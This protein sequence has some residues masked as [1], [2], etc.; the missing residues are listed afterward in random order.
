MVVKRD[1]TITNYEVRDIRF[2]TSQHLDGS[3]AMNK[4][5]DY[6]AAYVIFY[7]DDVHVEG[8]GMTFTC[9]RGT[10]VCCSAIEALAGKFINK[11]LS[12]LVADMRATHRICTGDSQLRWIGPEKGAIHLATA[13][14]INA[15]WDLWAKA[16]DKPLWKLV[17]D[18]SPEEFVQS[19]DF[20]YI[21]DAITPEEALELLRK[22]EPTKA[23]RELEMREKGY[24]AYT[25]SAGWLGYSDDKVRR[26]CR[27]A[28]AQGFTHFKQK[29]GGDKESDIRRAKLIREEIGDDGVL[30]MDANQVWDVNEAIEWME[31]LLQFKPHF[32][33]EPTSPDDVLGHAAIRKALYPRTRVATGEHI[34]NRII[35]KQLF[36]AEAIDF[37]QIDSCRVAGVNEILAILLMAKKFNIPVCP[38]AGGVGLCEYVQHLS[39]IDYI[40]VSATTEN[41]VLEYVDHLHEHFLEPVVMKNGRYMAPLAP[42]Y[43]IQ[44]KRDSIEDYT[45]P[46]GKIHKALANN[47]S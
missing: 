6:S 23:Q 24:P 40:C 27:E 11:K 22:N 8:H 34:Q 45:F 36:Q 44:M 47:K 46:G 38:H 30:M 9:G 39:L 17:V 4:D 10:E 12:E 42:G 18:L 15:V 28:K 37:C 19:I 35:F 43:S 1:Y 14:V 21:T 5:P 32:I 33:E 2:P 20:R 3:D 26:L 7:T 25:T 31:D 16:E 29:V 41:R 13:A